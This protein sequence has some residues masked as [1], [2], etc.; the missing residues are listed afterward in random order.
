MKK[1]KIVLFI[2]IILMVYAIGG[3]VY[4]KLNKKTEIEKVSNL[5][6]IKDY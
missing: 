1:K 5:D 4:L 6:I 2:L 3:I